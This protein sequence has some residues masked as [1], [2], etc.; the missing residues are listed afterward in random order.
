[1]KDLLSHRTGLPRYDLM[2]FGSDFTREEL[3]N[4][5]KYLKPNAS[6]RDKWQYNNLM[7]LVAGVII[8]KLS[9]IT[10]ENFVKTRIFV[11]LGM[12]ESNTSVDETI[13]SQDYSLAYHLND[14]DKAVQIPLHNINAIGPAG[15]INSNVIDMSKWL[16]FQINDGV[17][18][19]KQLVSKANLTF[20]HK[21][22]AVLGTS[23]SP[24]LSDS[25]YGLAWVIQE[26]RGRKLVWHNGSIDGFHAQISFLPKEKI[27]VVVLSNMNSSCHDLPPIITYKV[28]DNLLGLKPVDW[29]G[30]SLKKFQKNR[31]AQ[32]ESR[33]TE[34]EARLKNTTPSHPLEDYAGEYSNPA[35][36]T[37]TVNFENNKLTGSFW[38]Y[39]LEFK[40]YQYDTFLMKTM[41]KTP[42]KSTQS[43]GSAKAQFLTDVAGNITSMS[44]PLEPTA[45]PVVFT[46]V[47]SLELKNLTYLSKFSGKYTLNKATVRI[48][49]ENKALMIY[50]SDNQNFEMLPMG[51]NWF[52]LKNHPEFTLRFDRN[53]QGEGLLISPS[54][55]GKLVKIKG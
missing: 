44:I 49:L 48:I 17:I 52:C 11:P 35:F 15:S 29:N 12:N 16:L 28:F 3:Y 50:F 8:D 38:K 34:M 21:P 40:H 51:Q 42:D 39:I 43:L 7:Y 6:F 18:N 2:W 46:R 1:M 26:Y 45:D 25:L 41:K 22:V 4:K 55:S 10:W 53:N 47:P 30:R 31:Q 54:V 27:G 32:K 20:T 14:K 24:E 33:K 19:G 36:G 37:L 5:L 9:G 23:S 13:K